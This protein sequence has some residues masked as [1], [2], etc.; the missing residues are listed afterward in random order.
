MMMAHEGSPKKINPVGK[1]KL[2]QEEI[3]YSPIAQLQNQTRQVERIP[4]A[5]PSST[6]L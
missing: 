4:I 1:E 6:A 2:L 3:D 5:T